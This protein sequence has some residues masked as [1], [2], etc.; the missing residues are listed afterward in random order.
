MEKNSLTF[1]ISSLTPD[2][3]SMARLAEY[4]KELSVLYGSQPHV[5]FESVTEGSAC[6]KVR[7]E[8]EAMPHV[9]ARLSLVKDGSAATDAT[10]AYAALDRLL[11]ADNSSASIYIEKGR[12]ILVFAGCS[13]PLPDTISV[14]QQT[15]IDGV[16]IKI[17][18]RDDTIPVLIR[19]PE[20]KNIRCV[21]RGYAQA[22]ELA[23]YYLDAPLRLH[24]LGKWVRDD[25]GWNL[26]Q[27]TI[28]S[29][30]VLDQTPAAQVLA[31]FA[32]VE[33]NLWGSYD[34]PLDEWKKMRGLD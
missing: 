4:L 13:Q 10:K 7:I 22:K 20:G 9:D 8:D 26:E 16:V 23:K 28:Q 5:H 18:G 15:T 31:Q 32:H 25:E 34:D 12:N 1:S 6:L 11:R 24:G 27:L 2:T 30:V 19:D 29:W 14:T 33:N 21:V 3:L 17:G